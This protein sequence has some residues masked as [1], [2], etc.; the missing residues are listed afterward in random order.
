[1]WSGAMVAIELIFWIFHGPA[2]VLELKNAF[3]IKNTYQAHLISNALSQK[4]LWHQTRDSGDL[5]DRINKARSGLGS[6][7]E[8]TFEVIALLVRI[9][10]TIGIL[11]YFSWQI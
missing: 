11:L 2:R 4:L 1:M 5:I 6:F 8:D 7:A 10:G 3:A 9:I